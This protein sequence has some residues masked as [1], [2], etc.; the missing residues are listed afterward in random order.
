MA[1][2]S[3]SSFR[4]FQFAPVRVLAHHHRVG[5][6]APG[7]ATAEQSARLLLSLGRA[8]VPDRVHL[9]TDAEAIPTGTRTEDVVDLLVDGAGEA[10]RRHP[11]VA[12]DTEEAEAD[13]DALAAERARDPR[14]A[15]EDDPRAIRGEDTTGG[16][17]RGH[18]PDPGASLTP[19]AGR[20]VQGRGR[21]RVH[22]PAQRARGRALTRPTRGIAGAGQGRGVTVPAG[23]AIAGMTL[24]TAGPDL[25]FAIELC[26]H[27]LLSN[28]FSCLLLYFVLG[29]SPAPLFFTSKKLIF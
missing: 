18:G 20:P 21:T 29:N 1:Q 16:A 22:T 19:G 25:Q 4:T 28:F 11:V 3:K 24:G 5:E 13:M 7:H 8:P 10:G 15:G 12:G 9:L 26:F 23:G 14:F 6:E 27:E 2:S 17:D